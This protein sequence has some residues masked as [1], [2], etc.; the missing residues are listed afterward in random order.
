MYEGWRQQLTKCLA[1][2]EAIIDFGDDAQIDKNLIDVI[3]KDVLILLA[4]INTH[5]NDNRKGERLRAGLQ[6]V[7]VGPPNSGK[8]S[9]LNMLGIKN[10]FICINII[11]SKYC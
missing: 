5:L 2:I 11:N 10:T 3:K 9:L 6:V 7:I 1:H 4:S 8:S